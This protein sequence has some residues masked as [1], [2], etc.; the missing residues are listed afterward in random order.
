MSTIPR[1]TNL[2][3]AAIAAQ[4]TES[5]LTFYNVLRSDNGELELYG[6]RNNDPG[7]YVEAKGQLELN[8]MA[9]IDARSW[10]IKDITCTVTKLVLD[11]WYEAADDEGDMR[12]T[13][14]RFRYEYPE[15][16]NDTPKTPGAGVDDP[17]LANVVHLA[18]PKWTV[19]WGVDPHKDSVSVY[20]P[21]AEVDLRKRLIEITF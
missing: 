18:T 17:S 5:D 19:K 10:G 7:R 9:E 8:W 1:G 14:E 15:A 2:R 16:T 13:G 4:L 6:D 3:A 20:S 12:E 21:R 11:G